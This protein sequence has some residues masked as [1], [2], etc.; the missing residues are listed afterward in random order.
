M[1]KNSLKFIPL[2]AAS[3]IAF[4]SCGPSE[5]TLPLGE[6]ESIEIKSD[7][8][9]LN[10]CENGVSTGYAD[11]GAYVINISDLG[12]Y[13]YSVQLKAVIGERI[14]V[15]ETYKVEFKITS[16]VDREAKWCFITGESENYCWA[17]GADITLKANEE[18]IYEE[19][20]KINEANDNGKVKITY[21]EA[22]QFSFG[23]LGNSAAG[24]ITIRDVKITK[25]SASPE[26][27][28]AP[29]DD[30]DIIISSFHYTSEIPDAEG[31]YTMEATSWSKQ[32]KL[33]HEET[34]LSAAKVKFAYKVSE[35][36]KFSD[37]NN[38]KFVAQFISEDGNVE[39]DYKPYAMSQIDVPAYDAAGTW[40]E[41]ELDLSQVYGNSWD[42]DEKDG[43]KASGADMTKV[44][45]LRINPLSGEGTVFLKNIRYVK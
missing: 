26:N 15:N 45:A 30:E 18:Y 6:N 20:V 11:N 41:V 17:A 25:V 16:S 2:A 1:K 31:I 19:D 5:P 23:K 12:E 32:L 4:I 10:N 42:V 7:D 3:L 36:W 9:V 21:D 43:K 34:D 14:E 33:V 35:D 28:P 39:N 13:D 44:V 40:K 22:F 8:W 38:A 29:A 24:K 37:N 27:Q